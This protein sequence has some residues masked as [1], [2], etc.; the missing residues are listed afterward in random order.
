MNLPGGTLADAV[1]DVQRRSMR[2]TRWEVVS[3]SRERQEP[4]EVFR[5]HQL[6]FGD[7]SE[8][9]CILK[10]FP[11]HRDLTSSVCSSH[12]DIYV[13]SRCM[14]VPHGAGRLFTCDDEDGE[15][16]SSSYLRELKEGTSKMLG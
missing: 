10:V 4:I 1:I 2:P 5:P 16:F 13:T 7:G 6:A 11:D 12:C 3:T 15:L 8:A 14:N 9:N